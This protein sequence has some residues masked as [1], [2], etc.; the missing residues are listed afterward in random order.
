MKPF[1]LNSHYK[2]HLSDLFYSLVKPMEVKREELVLF[3]HSLAQELAMNPQELLEH[4]WYFSGSQLPPGSIPLA[5]AY[6]GHQF[7]FY[8]RLG[9][10]PRRDRRAHTAGGPRCR[11]D[12]G[13]GPDPGCRHRARV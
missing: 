2:D 8:T 10:A 12:P 13:G 6:S 7:G 9:G 5:Q 11:G 4:P 1:M 3:N